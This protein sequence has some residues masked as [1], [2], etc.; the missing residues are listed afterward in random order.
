MYTIIN[1]GLISPGYNKNAWLH[2]LSYS[3]FKARHPYHTRSKMLSEWRRIKKK[4][5]KENSIENSNPM[6]GVEAHTFKSQHS[7][8]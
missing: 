8:L 1:N 4:K 5:K 6:S 7:H 3:E 2:L